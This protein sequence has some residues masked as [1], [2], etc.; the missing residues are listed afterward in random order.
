[1]SLNLTYEAAKN[2]IAMEL[3]TWINLIDFTEGTDSSGKKWI[4]GY[5][6]GQYSNKYYY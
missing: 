6:N 1:M 4:R 5:A 3:N 2:Q